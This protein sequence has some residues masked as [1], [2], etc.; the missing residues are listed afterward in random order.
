[1][2]ILITGATGFF[3]PYLI[4]E[5]SNSGEEVIGL[6]RSG[7]NFQ[8]DL[9]DAELTARMVREANPRLIIHAAAMTSVIKCEQKPEVAMRVNAEATRNIVQCL[10][11]NC[12][13]I[14]ISTDMIYSGEGLHR[15][16]SSTESPV[17][18]YAMTK[19]IG[20]LEVS[21]AKNF[22]IFR[23]NIYGHSMVKRSSS[24]ADFM[25]QGLKSGQPM[26]LFSNVLFS[27]LHVRTA[28]RLM[29]NAA[30]QNKMGIYNLGSHMGMS[31]LTFGLRLANILD[32]PIKNIQPVLYEDINVRRPLDMRM[33]VFSFEN[34]FMLDLP[35]M[36]DDM[37]NLRLD[38]WEE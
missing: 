9:T 37:M 1:M 15:E 33:N 32:L 38:Q 21:R 31:K 10:P 30:S 6:A 2:T 3:G 36:A 14:Y 7:A 13:L 35:M 26:K 11:E 18:M 27:P 20:E 19:Y 24:L 17:N 23:T 22:L 25:V 16:H 29:A 28:A 4:E 8:C 34:D 5:F 12:K